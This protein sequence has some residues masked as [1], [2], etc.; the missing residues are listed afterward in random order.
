MN[1]G[2]ATRVGKIPG[3]IFSESKYLGYIPEVLTLEISFPTL[4]ATVS[5][6]LSLKSNSSSAKEQSHLLPGYLKGKSCDWSI[7]LK[8]QESRKRGERGKRERERER[9]RGGKEE[10]GRG[11]RERERGMTFIVSVGYKWQLISN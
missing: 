11:K 7:T 3:I 9:E 1:G 8:D 6:L 4:E 2:E 10:R 5:N